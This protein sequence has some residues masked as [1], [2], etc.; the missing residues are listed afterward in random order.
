MFFLT[1]VEISMWVICSL[2]CQAH[3][4]V[5]GDIYPRDWVQ[6][7][8]KKSLETSPRDCT[9]STSFWP[10]RVGGSVVFKK[11]VIGSWKYQSHVDGGVH[12]HGGTPIFCPKWMFFFHGKS[13]I[14]MD[15]R[16][17]GTPIFRKP[18]NGQNIWPLGKLTV[19]YRTLPDFFYPL[20]MMIFHR[21]IFVD[22][23]VSTILRIEIE[24]TIQRKHCG[25][26]IT[27]SS[28]VD[29]PSCFFGFCCRVVRSKKSSTA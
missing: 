24:T 2:E 21:K 17:G 3:V 10:L 6:N 20:N 5:A 13:D 27:L 8:L 26:W 29:F 15:V 14:K 1:S 18:P 23:G 11:S 12:S 22:Q 9:V 7:Y 4:F 25:F 16:V 19:R 28:L